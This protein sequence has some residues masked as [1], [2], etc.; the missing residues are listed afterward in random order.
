M[1]KRINKR[2]KKKEREE[3]LGL[4]DETKDMLGIPETDSDESDSS[5]EEPSDGGSDESDVEGATKPLGARIGQ[6]LGQL[7]E[8]GGSDV[9]SLSGMEDSE[10][11]DEGEEMDEDVDEDEDEPPMTIPEALQNPLYSIQ[12]GSEVQRCILCPG[13]ELKHAK[14]A[15]VHTESSSHL[16]R[17]KRF[18]ALA[19]RIG[20][21][22]EDPRLLV[23][24]LDESVRIA[25]K[26]KATKVSNE[27]KV[28]R[29]ERRTAKRERRRERRAAQQTDE[30]TQEK[31]TNKAQPK[32]DRVLQKKILNRHSEAIAKHKG[33]SKHPKLQ[34]SSKPKNSVI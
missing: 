17:M 12:K 16:R 18:Q 15:S 28:S 13:K 34:K 5:D 10:E 33:K 20:D 19:S 1:Y 11:E 6:K 32:A 9:E 23:A 3:A 21:E 4:D 7:S 24:A 2:I 31:Q 8:S 27:T 29:K 22:E 14:M 25:P 26:E 30:P